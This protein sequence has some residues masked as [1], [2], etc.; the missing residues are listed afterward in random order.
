MTDK[1]HARGGMSATA[2]GLTLAITPVPAFAQ[3]TPPSQM[4]A[5]DAM[6]G[7]DIVV[8]ARKRSESL[9]D[10]PISVTVVGAQQLE[11]QKINDIADLTRTIPGVFIQERSVLNTSI[12]IRGVGGDPRNVGLESGVN[13]T[14]D[15]VT[16]GRT[17]GYNA[18]LLDIAQVE[19]LRGP[20]GTLF[21][22]NTIG[23]VINITTK[24]PSGDAELAA[25]A[26]IGNYG[27]LR[28]TAKASG[29]LADNL[30]VGVSAQRWRREG[31]V[32]NT[33]TRMRYNDINR[34]G[35]R[36]QLVWEPAP[37]LSVYVV[38][39][40]TR[41]RA[42]PL[43]VQPIPPYIGNVAGTPDRYT[44]A[45]N[46][47]NSGDRDIKSAAATIDYDVGGGF[48]LTSISGYK[49][50]KT[51][52]FS[53]GDA[54]SRDAQNTGPFTDQ[55]RFLTQELRLVSPSGSPFRYVA[56]LYYLDEHV[57]GDRFIYANGSLAAG[58]VTSAFI[59]TK[60]YAGYLNADYDFTGSLSANGGVRYNK[61]DKRGRYS[62]FRQLLPTLTF[63]FPNLSRSDE[64]VS[65]TGS[66]RYK[67]TSDISTYLTVSRGF[68]SGGFNVDL[69][70][71]VRT[72]AATIN[73]RPERLTNYEA[74]VKARLFDR[75]LALNAAVYR[76][77]YRDRQ[78]S[79]FVGTTGIASIY[80]TNAGR[81]KA[82]GA[83]IEASLFLPGDL[84][85]SA[86]GSY[87]HSR[88]TSFENATAAG[89]SYTGNVTEFTPEYTANLAADQTVQL[90]NV[91]DLIY[92]VA[93]RYQG[94][95]FFDAANNPLNVQNGYWLVDA[96]AGF[97]L[98]VP[99]SAT[100]FGIYLWAKNL[101]Q[102]DYLVLA[103]QSQGVNQGQYGEPRTFGLELTAGF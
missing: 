87:I 70:G 78:V 41:D 9:L 103:R 28:T 17:N 89:A 97:R 61:E 21:G 5:D 75:R 92:N 68:K 20:Q 95:L 32:Y 8:T 66:L 83:E 13:V 90:S 88:Y 48:A 59:A 86:S 37:A 62:Q 54:S 18:G 85:L 79:S 3:E 93:A 94:K 11:H 77:D 73:F 16:A 14:V 76:N 38:G 47:R 69:A 96:R 98:N 53:D 58:A 56:G 19:V 51:N 40:A 43:L 7:G 33:T 1:K 15:G 100:T 60:A 82:T 91:V 80:I 50:I 39:D 24:R 23:G 74:G 71:D 6:P 84:T 36:V 44:V 22:T 102:R 55:S 63:N 12:S 31:Y 45:A 49:S 101:T 25:V 52:V 64:A 57:T 10:V 30:F 99:Q 42:N 72:T 2:L 65:W 34:L 35:G 46:Q 26:D 81:S 4:A 67:L 29:G 27:A